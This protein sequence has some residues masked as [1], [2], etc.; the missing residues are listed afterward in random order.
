[1]DMWYGKTYLGVVSCVLAG[2]P[3]WVSHIGYLENVG[4]LIYAYLPNV[5]VFILKI[6]FLEAHG[7]LSR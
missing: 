5:N 1:M 6:T 3:L 4:S 7:T 2:L